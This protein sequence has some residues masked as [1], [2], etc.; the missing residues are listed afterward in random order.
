M[1]ELRRVTGPP[2]GIDRHLGPILVIVLIAVI[3]AVVKPWGSAQTGS[4]AVI[5]PSPGPTQNPSAAQSRPA[6]PREYHIVD[7]GVREP[8]PTWE[9]WSAGSLSSFGFAMRVDVSPSVVPLTSPAA[10]PEAAGSIAPVTA[11]MDIP[12]VWPTIEIPP[13][14]QLDLIALNRPLG[15][16]IAVV[17]FTRDVE[18]GGVTALPPILGV[19]PW[20][21]HFTEI[22]LGDGDA[23]D[24]MQHWPPGTY[25]LELAIGPGTDTRSLEVIVDKTR[26]AASPSAPAPSG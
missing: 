9:I 13:G 10:T 14:N 7:F 18:G 5:P 12:A 20:P 16:T 19:S 17:G 25:H 2:S 15:H 21:S 8:P 22:G 3:V 26:P 24:G 23:T 1:S 6:G 4:V 11:A